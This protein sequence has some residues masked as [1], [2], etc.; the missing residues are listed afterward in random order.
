[1]AYRKSHIP[2]FPVVAKQLARAAHTRLY[3]MMDEYSAFVTKDFVQ[4]I[5]DQR[6]AS[7]RVIL[8][9]ESGTNLSPEWLDRKAEAGADSRTMIATGHYTESIK[10]FKKLKKNGRGGTWRVGF[11]P[12]EQ[13]RDLHG[14]RVPITLA[15]VALFQ[16]HG[17]GR[18]P[19]RPH[20]SPYRNRL[21]REAPSV[22]RHMHE[23]IRKAMKRAAK[24]RI[25]VG[26]R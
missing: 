20:W 21:K 2:N 4:R 11:D 6:F 5:K 9:P 13:A 16:E 19:A 7:F 22:R 23:E 17:T 26:G 25:I 14:E 18:V 10:T 12:R 24:G 1:M 8:Y 3:E 15:K